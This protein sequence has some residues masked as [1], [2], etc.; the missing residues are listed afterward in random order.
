MSPLALGGGSLE[1]THL[2]R[3]AYLDE[4][5]TSA[6]LN[7][8][9]LVVASVL[10]NADEQWIPVE[11]RLLEIVEKCRKIKPQEDIIL[12]ATDIFSGKKY[13]TDPPFSLE[14]RISL[15]KEISAIPKD[16]GLPIIHASIVR[17]SFDNAFPMRDRKKQVQLQIVVT[18]IDCTVRIE[19]YMR[20]D[21]P[22]KE[23]ATLVY[24]TNDQVKERVRQGHELLRN[25]HKSQL[26]T[27]ED[28][29]RY[30]PPKRIVETAHFAEK[31]NSSILQLADC[32]AFVIKRTLANQKHCEDYFSALLPQIIFHDPPTRFRAP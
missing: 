24:E 27:P 5:G 28:Y 25:P 3:F 15:L 11:Q 20:E 21:V 31:A 12:H 6:N 22:A 8:P 23:V 1:G 2:V 30:I 10:V 4:A 13:F 29:A 17:H 9:I 14:T 26:A 19:K 16:L 18:S 7:E 32:A